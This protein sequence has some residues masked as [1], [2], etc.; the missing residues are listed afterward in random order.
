MLSAH[1]QKGHLSPIFLGICSFSYFPLKENFSNLLDKYLL[2]IRLC[3]GIIFFQGH[4]G[5]I[6]RRLYLSKSELTPWG[7]VGAFLWGGSI[8]LSRKLNQVVWH[9][10][11]EWKREEAWEFVLQIVES[12]TRRLSKNF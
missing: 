4:F 1:E 6:C 2:N 7:E 10:R 3:T 9:S 8:L 12:E 11:R 5:H